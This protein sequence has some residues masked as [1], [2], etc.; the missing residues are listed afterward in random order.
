ME[1]FFVTGGCS[2]EQQLFTGVGKC[3][4][5]E[6]VVDYL[7]VTRSTAKF[8]VPANGDFTETIKSALALDYKDPNKMW[9]IGKITTNNAPEGGDM[10]T[11]TKGTRG[12]SITTGQNPISIAY[13]M[14]A[15]ICLF[16]QLSKF[17]GMEC[18]VF[19]LD[20]NKNVFGVFN[21]EENKLMGFSASI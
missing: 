11:N 4:V 6:G 13:A 12:G 9:I 2:T 8:D 20:R 7:L 5:A 15:G 19:R 14:P 10:I 3:D 18:R 21:A 16:N 1:K 17:N